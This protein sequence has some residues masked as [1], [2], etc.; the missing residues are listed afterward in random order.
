MTTKATRTAHK[1]LSTVSARAAA[2]ITTE[3]VRQ[4]LLALPFPDYAACVAVLMARMGYQEV[5]PLGPLHE[6]GRNSYGAHDIRATY[7]QGLT[8]SS[9]IAQVKQYAMP[10]PRSFVDELRGAMLRTG[11]QQAL[12]FTTSSFAPAAI[13][14]VQAGQHTAPIRLVAGEELARL[15]FAYR[16][17][18]A[19]NASSSSARTV[20]RSNVACLKRESLSA[21]GSPKMPRSSRPVAAA[22][23]PARYIGVN[24]TV[25]V[26]PP[27]GPSKDLR[28]SRQ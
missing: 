11:A 8:K 12:L 27:S 23:P 13:E 19:S 9:V 17:I 18:L 15:M 24:V 14:A 6:K 4:T 7:V 2:P 25:L 10:V 20:A 1:P 26:S 16:M 3:Q 22:A 21:P 5:R 28:S